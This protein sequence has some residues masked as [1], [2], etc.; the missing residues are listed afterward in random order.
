MLNHIIIMGRLVRDPELRNTPSGTPVTSFTLAVDRDFKSRD[1]GE[2]STDFID[3]VAWRQTAEFVNKYFSKGRMAV[4]EGRLQIRDWK[5][6]DGNNRRSAEVIANNVYFGDSKRDGDG[7]GSYG[8][9]Y[10]GSSYGNGG[11]GYTP[12]QS[13]GNASS[14]G[15]PSYGAPSDG[16]SGFAEIDDQDGDLPF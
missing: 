7:G 11:G 2:R 14:Y 1:S 10:G 15:T 9:S 4:V 5:D 13:Y 6:K 12:P 16:G 8:A 3:V